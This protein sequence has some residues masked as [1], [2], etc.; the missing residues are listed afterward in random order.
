MADSD[1]MQPRTFNEPIIVDGDEVLTAQDFEESFGEG[2]QRT[3]DLETWR[4]GS[5]LSQEYARVAQEVRDA[6]ESETN[7]QKRIRAEVF[8]RLKTQPNAPRNAGR[9]TADENAI[10]KIHEHLLFRGGI[11][12]CDG[13]M[14]THA[15]LPLTI[16]QMGV[17]LVSY[18]GNEGTWCQR[19][20]RHDL[21]NGGGEPIE[22]A[23]AILERRKKRSGTSD[24]LG[25]LAQKAILT[26]AERAILLH[27]SKAPWRM[28]VGNPVTYELLTGGSNLEMMVAATTVLRDLVEKHQKFVFVSREPREQMLLTI[29]HAL[30]PMEFAIVRTLDVELDEWL[31]QRRYTTQDSTKL[32]W[33]GE[34][35][36][37]SQWIPR[38]IERVASKIV[39]G[40]FRTTEA[41]PAQIFYA[42]ADHSDFAA[43]IALADSMLQRHRGVPM[44]IDIA[45][46][47][48]QT[49]FGD[50]LAGIAEDAYAAAG[51]PWRYAYGKSH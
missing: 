44:L 37:P 39:V 12:A 36:L 46:H 16:Y 24:R 20:F 23:I 1:Q 9:H 21:R 17:T 5:D 6:V 13:A 40:L 27:R 49:V 15:T 34:M 50:S 43:H 48:C 42:H 25:E 7:L 19:L 18:Q 35:I 32:P 33:D 38:F 2:I 4:V 30:H 28:G 41:A 47:V 14:Q 26:Y 29:A 11:E 10:A 31:H 22:E 51:V 45:R 3:L 8:P